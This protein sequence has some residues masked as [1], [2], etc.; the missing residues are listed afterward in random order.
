MSLFW[1]YRV[2]HTC[3]LFRIF[4]HSGEEVILIHH[5]ECLVGAVLPRLKC[6][7][8][9]PDEGK[10]DNP[11]CEKKEA[12]DPSEGRAAQGFYRCD[13]KLRKGIKANHKKTF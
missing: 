12:A 2:Q 7:V 11:A 6:C 5:H 4:G 13:V 9:C 3:K 8:A 1:L 10:R